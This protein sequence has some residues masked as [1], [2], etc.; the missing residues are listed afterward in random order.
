METASKAIHYFKTLLGATTKGS[1]EALRLILVLC[2]KLADTRKEKRWELATL[3]PLELASLHT[4]SKVR[5]L[6]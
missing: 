4:R 6:D 5:T 2:G 1:Q 3:P